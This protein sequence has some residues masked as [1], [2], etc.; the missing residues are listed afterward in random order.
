MRRCPICQGALTEARAGAFE[1]FRCH[2]GHAFSIE[3]LLREQSESLERALWAA[4]RALEESSG[5]SQRLALRESG[6]LSQRF[7]EKAHTQM[8]Q[9]N[10]IREIL[11]QGGLLTAPDANGV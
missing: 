7:S 2:V 5:L 6:K 3:S 11:L 4:V 9:A 1:H 10:L 8:D